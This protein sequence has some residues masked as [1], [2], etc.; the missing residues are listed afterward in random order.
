MTKQKFIEQ[1]KLRFKE[2]DDFDLFNFR[3]NNEIITPSFNVKI[4][5]ND[6]NTFNICRE[7]FIR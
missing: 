6:D 4:T 1:I 5:F 3:Q 2:N 7:F